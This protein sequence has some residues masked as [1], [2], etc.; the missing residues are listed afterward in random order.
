M[1]NRPQELTGLDPVLSAHQ[2]RWAMGTARRIKQHMEVVGSDGRHVGIVDELEGVE[3]IKLAKADPKAGG[4][5][6]FIPC[7]WVE[8]VGA[9][10]H[11]NKTSR[12]AIEQW[13]AAE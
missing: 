8:R 3:R 5:H 10:V 6:H 2:R 12:E 13:E 11:L 1:V 7:E 4:R 9:H